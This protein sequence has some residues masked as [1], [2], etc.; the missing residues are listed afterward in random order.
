M[1][2]FGRPP[3]VGE[4][5]ANFCWWRVPRGQHNGSQRQY[6]RISRPKPLLFLPSSSSIVLTRL[7]GPRSRATTSQEIWYCQGYVAVKRLLHYRS[8]IV[9]F[10]A[11]RLDIILLGHA[12]HLS[13]STVYVGP[14]LNWGRSLR[15]LRAS[16]HLQAG[17]PTSCSRK[18]QRIRLCCEEN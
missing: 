15:G 2:Y 13:E 3:L 18:W 9:C 14:A 17:Q 4:V 5:S 1:N 10:R 7:S 16:A 11:G 12:K 6:S 8:L